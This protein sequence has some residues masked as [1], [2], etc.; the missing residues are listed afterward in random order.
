[1]YERIDR[2][3]KFIKKHGFAFSSGVFLLFNIFTLLLAVREQTM[4]GLGFSAFGIGFQLAMILNY[5]IIYRLNKLIDMIMKGYGEAVDF[6]NALT[7]EIEKHS[8]RKVLMKKV[9]KSKHLV[10]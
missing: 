9:P 5:F 3:M 8:D 6:V 1:M 10:N 7:K 2:V 4:F